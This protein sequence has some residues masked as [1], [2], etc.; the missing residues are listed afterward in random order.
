[1]FIKAKFSYTFHLVEFVVAYRILYC[2]LIRYVYV[3][4]QCKPIKM[5]ILPC[6]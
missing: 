2:R 5:Y 3:N 1:M 4:I 6:D